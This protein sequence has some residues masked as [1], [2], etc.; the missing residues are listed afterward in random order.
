M[1]E[2]TPEGTGTKLEK[3][4]WLYI[5]ADAWKRQTKHQINRQLKLLSGYHVITTWLLDNW[6]TNDKPHGGYV[7]NPETLNVTI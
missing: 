5:K 1:N 2:L 3:E 4:N 6:S 7:R